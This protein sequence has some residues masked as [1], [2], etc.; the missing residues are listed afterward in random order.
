MNIVRCCVALAVLALSVLTASADDLRTGL[1]RISDDETGQVVQR[2]DTAT[3]GEVRLSDFLSENLSEASLLSVANDNSLYRL[4]LKAGPIPKGEDKGRFAVVVAGLCMPVSSHSDRREDG[5]LE[6]GCMVAGE[7][8]GKT[9]A[10]ALGIEPQLRKHPGHRLLVTVKPEQP[11]YRP[12][13][14]VTLVMTI[15]NVGETTVSFFDGGQQRGPRN[16]Q[17]SFIAFSNAGSGRALPD[18]GD[19][20][21]LGG[22]AGIKR[23]G[24]GDVFTKGVLLTDWFKFSEPD[25]FQITAIYQLGLLGEDSFRTIWEDFAVAQCLV[26]VS[27]PEPA[28]H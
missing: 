12:G 5:S 16:N 11:G 1:Y 22:L 20:T 9:I 6:I 25:S 4:S 18:T 7:K 2:S 15:K 24:P 28:N 14:A 26:R 21:N 13:E 8:A 3:G 27:A 10:E 17:F 19:P 23:L